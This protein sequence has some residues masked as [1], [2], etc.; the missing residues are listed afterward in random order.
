MN[1]IYFAFSLCY[2]RGERL[3]P[4]DKQTIKMNKAAKSY[5]FDS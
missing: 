1:Q 3:K 4:I 2:M 5:N